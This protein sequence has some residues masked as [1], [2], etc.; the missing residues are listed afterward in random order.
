MPTNRSEK[1]KLY[2]KEYRESHKESNAVYHK[3]WAKDNKDKIAVYGKRYKDSHPEV[4]KSRW[5]KYY[6]ENK[7]IIKGRM[8]KDTAT[9]K[10]AVFVHYSD[11]SS[12]YKCNCKGCGFVSNDPCFY[13][14]DHINNDGAK[15]RKNHKSRTG[16]GLYRWIIKVG[17]PT[18]LQILCWNCNC[19][20]NIN[21]GVCPHEEGKEN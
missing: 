20:K 17:F 6:S 19:A 12:G 10:D 9:M 18:D 8:N 11:C 3:E 4:Q 16:G 7:E 21:G 2:E 1:R 14:I 15:F 5:D 13:S